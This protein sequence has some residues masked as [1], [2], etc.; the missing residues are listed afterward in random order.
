MTADTLGGVLNYAEELSRGLVARGF[1]IFLATM[2]GPLRPGQRARL[3]AIGPNMSVL[4]SR[5][6]L[7]W[8]HDPWEDVERSGRW[9]LDIAREVEPDLVHLNGYSHGSLSFCCP[10]VVVAHSCV[11]SWWRSVHG[12][13]APRRF[14]V[15]RA[16]VRQGL[17]GAHAVVTPSRAMLDAVLEDYGLELNTTVIH[18]GRSTGPFPTLGKHP[19]VLSLGR[20]WDEAKNMAAL[21][22]AARGLPWP[23][24][25]AG[26]AGAGGAPLFRHAEYWR[27]VSEPLLTSLLSRAAIYALPA[28]YEPFGLSILEAALSGAALV[29]GDIPSLREIWDEAALFADPDDAPGLRRELEKLMHGHA[30]RQEMARRARARALRYSAPRMTSKYVRLYRSLLEEDQA[31]L[32]RKGVACV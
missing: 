3:E 29:L 8:M 17:L 24:R 19:F 22:E 30:L 15:Y 27:N 11:L 16:R 2:G 18:N 23:V 4:E 14:N 28:R 1:R 32:L 12:E 25:I 5:F 26:S 7:E 6:A 31:P 20:V 13:P 9:L 21:D 10:I